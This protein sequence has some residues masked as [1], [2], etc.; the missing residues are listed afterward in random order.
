MYGYI[1][2]IH[3]CR[4]F[5]PNS[6][7]H[8]HTY[9]HT[10]IHVCIPRDIQKSWWIILSSFEK[11]RGKNSQLCAN[12]DKTQTRN[13]I[14][15]K[16]WWIILSS[17]SKKKRIDTNVRISVILM[18]I[19]KKNRQKPIHAHMC[20]ASPRKIGVISQWTSAKWTKIKIS[21]NSLIYHIV[22]FLYVCLYVYMY[23]CMY[24]GKIP[25]YPKGLWRHAVRIAW[26]TTLCPFCMYVFLLYVSE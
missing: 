5:M 7:L 19:I 6:Q 22:P 15:S 13:Q 20:V 3:K 26:F 17:F 1:H 12:F 16:Q 9:M 10:H 23:V 4:L 25:Q 2:Y 8:I 18:E 21:T 11:K 14:Y 24:V